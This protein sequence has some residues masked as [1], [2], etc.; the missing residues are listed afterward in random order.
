MFDFNMFPALCSNMLVWA[1]VHTSVLLPGSTFKLPQAELQG[2]RAVNATGP[3]LLSKM[4]RGAA[5][6]RAES[7]GGF[8]EKCSTCCKAVSP[9]PRYL[10]GQEVQTKFWFT[11]AFNRRKSDAPAKAKVVRDQGKGAVSVQLL[12]WVNFSF[13]PVVGDRVTAYVP[14]DTT[15]QRLS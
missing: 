14:L 11:E 5:T 10:R 4:A 12:S 13:S 9:E 8:A 6:S 3:S 2:V 1:L 15:M 7:G